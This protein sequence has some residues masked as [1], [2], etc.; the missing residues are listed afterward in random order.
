M[1][2]FL[3][4]LIASIFRTDTQG[5]T[6]RYKDLVGRLQSLGDGESDTF[7][8]W[9]I[10]SNYGEYGF[11]AKPQYVKIE[12][13]DDPVKKPTQ[14][15]NVLSACICLCDKKCD[16]V[17][18]CNTIPGITRFVVSKDFSNNY[19]LGV[20]EYYGSDFRD[21]EFLAAIG[22]YKGISIAGKIK[23]G[24]QNNFGRPTVNISRSG[25]TLYFWP[26]TKDNNCL[27]I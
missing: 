23:L 21:W 26:C 10:D 1:I 2:L 8:L 9:Q 22:E 14:K 25:D 3:L 18:E 15:C 19:G 17:H 5:T 11:N 16:K 6:Q 24:G 27:K 20:E 7:S 12:E 13:K 4:W